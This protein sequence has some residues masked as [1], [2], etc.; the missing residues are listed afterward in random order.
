VL[1]RLVKRAGI[2]ASALVE[3]HPWVL[4]ITLGCFVSGFRGI[5]SAPDERLALDRLVGEPYYAMYYS[6][7]IVGGLVLLASSGF[8]GLRDRL[9]VEQIGLWIVS[10]A[11]LIY[12]VAIIVKF[13][14][15][16]G[17][18]AVITLLIALGGI[19]RIWRIL[20]ELRQL[21]QESP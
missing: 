21:T 18:A 20:W 3:W 5:T 19:A 15:P 12:Q 16:A 1:D 6:S 13:G 17:V 10:G 14:Q 11:L 4:A 2:A 9:M 7:L 8:R